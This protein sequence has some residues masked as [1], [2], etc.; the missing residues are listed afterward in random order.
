MNSSSRCMWII[1]VVE[2]KNVFFVFFSIVNKFVDFR[3]IL[4]NVFFVVIFYMNDKF[5]L[6]VMIVIF[7]KVGIV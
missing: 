2:Y 7:V 6:E 3:E 1:M 5:W 4:F